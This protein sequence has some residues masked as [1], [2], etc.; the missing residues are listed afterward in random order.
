MNLNLTLVKHSN[1][2]WNNLS[3]KIFF[4]IVYLGKVCIGHNKLNIRFV[5]DL[6]YKKK[7]GSFGRCG[8]YIFYRIIPNDTYLLTTRLLAISKIKIQK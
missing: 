7:L 5:S 1:K 6:V 2:T 3:N 4:S 8:Y